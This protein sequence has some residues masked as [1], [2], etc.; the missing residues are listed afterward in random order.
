MRNTVRL[1]NAIL[2]SAAALSFAA[3]AQADTTLIINAFLPAQH[4]LNVKVLKPWADDVAKATEGR[5]KIQIPPSSVAAPDQLWNSVRNGVVDGAYLFNGTVQGQLKLM[6]MPHLPFMGTN[7]RGNSVALWRTYEKYFKAAAEY[8]DVHLL[9]TVVFPGGIL[10]SL[11]APIESERNLN[12]IKV[13]ALPGVP[14]KL[15]SMAKAGVI[16]TPAAKMSELVAGGT[17]EAFVGI[18]DM[19]AEA[20]KV[21]RYA[22]SATTV[23]GTLSNPSF[24]LIVNKQKWESISPQDRDTITKL[25]GEAFAERM[26][27]F[28]QVESAAHAAAMQAGL[29]YLA[30]SPQLVAELDKGAQLLKAEWLTAAKKVNV[31]G[32]DAIRFYMAQ[33][34]GSK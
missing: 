19:D 23:P 21:I 9:A 1:T 32:E 8:K 18:P 16:S 5:V 25:S 34:G 33:S 30:A 28:D 10:Y 3:P 22:K 31:N 24:S 17:V 15:M 4:T 14:A 7:A 27:A 11:K 13:W 29:K 20:F 12:G 6:Q 2:I 26:A